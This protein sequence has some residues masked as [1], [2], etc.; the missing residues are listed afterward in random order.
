MPS[1][2]V[3]QDLCNIKSVS[4]EVS[5]F[6]TLLVSLDDTGDQVVIINT[7]DIAL[8]GDDWKYNIYFHHTGYA[9]GASYTPAWEMH[10][11][12][13]IYVSIKYNDSFCR[14]KVRYD[15]KNYLEL[16]GGC[17]Q[18]QPPSATRKMLLLVL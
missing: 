17:C 8:R 18:P 1:W 7:R 2:K 6:V 5:I 12:N 13:P 10:K 16:V 14:I 15:V 3:R 11:K 4:P 9:K